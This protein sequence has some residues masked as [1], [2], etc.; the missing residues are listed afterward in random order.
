[1]ASC[2]RWP[3][4]APA[5][6]CP[7]CARTIPPSGR[8]PRPCHACCRSS[9]RSASRSTKTRSRLPTCPPS[10]LTHHQEGAQY[11]LAYRLLVRSWSMSETRIAKLFKN[12]SSQAVRLPAEFRFDGEEVY[13]TRDD[14]TGDVVLSNRP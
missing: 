3:R 4:P 10:E 2:A 1:M 12:G 8:S 6:C 14:V 11:I 5:C 7:T 9:A 13:V